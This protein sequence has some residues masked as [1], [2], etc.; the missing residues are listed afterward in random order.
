MIVF[1]EENEQ[2]FDIEL[3]WACRALGV[4]F[5]TVGLVKDSKNVWMA[6]FD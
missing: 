6:M 3:G 1:V 4:P 2:A 5:L